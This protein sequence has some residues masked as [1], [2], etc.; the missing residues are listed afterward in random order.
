MVGMEPIVLH[1]QEEAARILRKRSVKSIYRLRMAGRLAWIPGH[2]IMITDEAL[3]A[4]LKS[5]ETRPTARE[6]RAW[7]ISRALR[8]VRCRS[9]DVDAAEWARQLIERLYD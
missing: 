7:K 2:P 4:Y 9:P 6:V 3:R 1:T 5:T 8:P